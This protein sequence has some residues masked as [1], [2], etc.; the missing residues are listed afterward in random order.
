MNI[1]TI[2]T[3][4]VCAISIILNAQTTPQVKPDNS[5]EGQFVKVIDKSSNYQEFKVIKKIKLA[6][7]RKNILDSI[8]TLEKSIETKDATIE[9]QESTISE[10]QSNLSATQNNL[11]ISKEK[12]DGIELFG[13]MTKKGTYNTIMFS[14][15]G[16]L[17]LGLSFF[18]FRF[19]N[20]NSITRET[21]LKLS[22]VET[23]FE[24]YRQK[25]LEDEQVLRRKLQ[26][27]INKNR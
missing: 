3:L 17:F 20:S 16:L 24:A 1:K 15:I 6:G 22:E 23:A 25:K 5:I 14:I 11:T 12:E 8:A 26:D 13:M 10:L 21:N 18:I 2:L 19:K 7:L 27:E 4:S 9:S